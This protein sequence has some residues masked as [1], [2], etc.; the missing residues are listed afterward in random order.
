MITSSPSAT[1]RLSHC[2]PPLA[3]T[4]SFPHRS[5]SEIFNESIDTLI[6]SGEYGVPVVFKNI[7]GALAES[8]DSGAKDEEIEALVGITGTCVTLLESLCLM[9]EQK[10]IAPK[11]QAK[12]RFLLSEYKKLLEDLELFSG[13]ITAE[14]C[15]RAAYVSGASSGW[16]TPEEDAAWRDL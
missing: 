16:D 1:S 2:L 6:K 4:F 13:D 7:R 15:F 9:T 12:L 14:E 10:N 3:A 8:D 5:F 11:K